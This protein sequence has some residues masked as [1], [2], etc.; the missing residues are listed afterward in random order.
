MSAQSIDTEKLYEIFNGLYKFKGLDVFKNEL[1]KHQDIIRSINPKFKLREYQLEALGR[2]IHYSEQ[3]DSRQKPYHLLFNMAT[4]SGKTLVMA[5]AM[6]YLYKKGYRNFVFFTHLS[7]I[8]DKTKDNFL[9]PQSSKY[10]FAP[11]ISLS[12][13]KISIN[14]VGGFNATEDDNINIMFTTM[15]GLH[16]K[17]QNARENGLSPEDIDDKKIVLLGDEAH[18]FSAKTKNKSK[19]EEEENNN[20][21][22]TI[23]A[24]SDSDMGHNRPGLL[25]VN[26]N[27]ENILL[28]FTATLKWDDPNI[29]K[30]YND[31]VILRY[32]LAQFRKDGYSKN[33]STLQF[34]AP[35]FDRVLAAIIL[36]QYRLK[37]SQDFNL[38]PNSIKPVILFKANR[39]SE[40]KDKDKARGNNPSIV[41]SG[42]FKELFHKNINE[43]TPQKLKEIQTIAMAM[44]EEDDDHGSVNIRKAFEFFTSKKITL[45]N[46]A[47]EIKRDFAPENCLS[48]DTKDDTIDNQITLNSLEDENNNIRAV[49]ATEKL[50]EGW[51]VL[52]LFDIVRLYDSRDSRDNKPGRTTVQEA[53][54]IG[55]GARYCPFVLDESNDKHVRKFDEYPDHPLAAL[56][57]LHYHCTHNPKYIKELDQALIDQGSKDKE[58]EEFIIEP[59]DN[60]PDIQKK[61]KKT[62]WKD[63]SI[64]LNKR[65]LR[66]KQETTQ[67]IDDAMYKFGTN[68]IIFKHS[69]MEIKEEDVGTDIDKI[70]AEYAEDNIASNSLRVPFKA[71][72]L[73]RHILRQA[74]GYYPAANFDNLVKYFDNIKSIDNFI[75][76]IDERADELILTTT[77]ER[78]SDF[79]QEE[80]LSIAKDLM[81]RLLEYLLV[82]RSEHIGT[83]EFTAKTLGKIFGDSKVR[84]IRERKSDDY[85]E[86]TQ[87][88]IKVLVN[89][90][91]FAQTDFRDATDQEVAFLKFI[92][93]QYAEIEKRYDYFLVFR[94]DNHFSIYNFE[95][96]SN[97]HDGEAFNPDFVMI[98]K[99][100]GV[101]RN[102]THQVFVEAKGPQFLG[103]DRKFTSGNQ[104]WKEDFLKRIEDERKISVTDS[105]VKVIGMPFFHKPIKGK[106]EHAIYKIFQEQ[107]QNKLLPELD[108]PESS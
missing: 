79:D 41:V 49:F 80:K 40:S 10:L 77:G 93:Q 31:K 76:I 56:E 24:D 104:G 3:Y 72:E 4:G 66:P 33:I 85:G 8:I 65:E 60:I 75:D 71:S 61:V 87:A 69:S 23:L 53:Q 106:G 45:E 102:I 42:E 82:D 98:L 5:T 97:G 7:N 89:K 107:F 14:E 64:F 92:D 105:N 68:G 100:K 22:H 83:K 15:S 86:Y 63:A 57:R 54:L 9:N 99:E 20:W 96:S 13:K 62:T 21:E 32:D 103:A 35:Y 29:E 73:G 11:E 74:L 27:K 47:K 2:F 6:L 28:E 90:E 84:Q 70:D 67:A 108:N 58:V 43:L 19:T 55:R 38:K 44:N 88:D 95:N 52:N 26:P 48:V 46:L 59:K 39:V 16:N 25:N 30:K 94:N 91:W 12:G 1:K 37:V 50:N 18:H 51:D 101:D 81:G 78:I 17:W 34:D 36:S